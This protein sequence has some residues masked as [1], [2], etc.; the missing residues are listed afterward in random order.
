MWEVFAEDYAH[1]MSSANYPRQGTICYNS[2]L[3]HPLVELI[4]PL[5]IFEVY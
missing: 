5:F 2:P 4:F 1:I 3:V